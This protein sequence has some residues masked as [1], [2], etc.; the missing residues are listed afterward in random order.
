M[1]EEACSRLTARLTA[2]VAQNDSRAIAVVSKTMKVFSSYLE[3]GDLVFS[4]E[5]FKINIPKLVREGVRI[6]INEA[7]A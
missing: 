2:R 6:E 1:L 7:V 5:I 3:N 4:G